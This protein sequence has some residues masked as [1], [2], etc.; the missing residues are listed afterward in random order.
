M[1]LD[2][3][4]LARR[5]VSGLSPNQSLPRLPVNEGDLSTAGIIA[6]IAVVLASL[7]GAILGGLAEMRFHRNVDK[8][9]LGA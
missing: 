3:A 8:A 2:V 6:A 9:G 1:R 7:A 4:S 5:D